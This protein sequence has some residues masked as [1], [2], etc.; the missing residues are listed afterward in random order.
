MY[1]AKNSSLATMTNDRECNEAEH[2]RSA[3]LN[4]SDSN[5]NLDDKEMKIKQVFGLALLLKRG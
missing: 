3:K 4:L 2:W 5:R 1:F